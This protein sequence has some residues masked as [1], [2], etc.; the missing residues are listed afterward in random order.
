MKQ[1]LKSVLVVLGIALAL[2]AL[3]V[4][5]I[6]GTVLVSFHLTEKCTYKEVDRL[7]SPTGRLTVV[8]TQRSCTW[9]EAPSPI[10]FFSLLPP[11]AP[12]DE[13][14][15]FFKTSDYAET[16][17]NPSRVFARWIDGN[18]LLIAAPD[19][20]AFTHAPTSAL[21]ARLSAALSEFDGI[22]IQYGVYPL[23]AGTTRNDGL[24]KVIEKRVIFEP[25]FGVNDEDG[26]PGV[27]CSLR[28]DALHG[29]YL[30]ELSLYLTADRWIGAKNFDAVRGTMVNGV[31]SSIGFEISAWDK[32][33]RSPDKYATRAEVA[34]FGEDD[35]KIWEIFLVPP[36]RKQPDGKPKWIFTFAP[37]N[38]DVIA[39]AEEL[40]RG[41]LTIRVGYWL[42]DIVVV[43]TMD[44]PIDPQPI[45]AFERCIAD[46]HL[47]DPPSAEKSRD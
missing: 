22:H 45:D 16:I 19:D 5:A 27:G 37:P 43:Y 7:P 23:D 40:R 30:D 44:R 1:L 26:A 2:S 42:D 15:T 39:I 32:T 21:S 10:L 25:T 46:N 34:G 11:G 18:D 33:V 8:R 14:K 13:K 28:V 31:L 38:R 17:S 6:F 4:A 29:E 24:K 41:S 36:G 9:D 47:F 3:V 35:D 20:A 12:F